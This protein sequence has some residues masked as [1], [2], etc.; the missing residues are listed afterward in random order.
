MVFSRAGSFVQQLLCVLVYFVYGLT[1][2]PIKNGALVL[3]P[4]AEITISGSIGEKCIGLTKAD[5]H[6][7]KRNTICLNNGTFRIL[8]FD[9]LGMCHGDVCHM[10]LSS[11]FTR[12][13]SSHMFFQQRDELFFD[14]HSTE[15]KL[16]NSIQK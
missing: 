15:N 5:G 4:L 7:R 16:L 12:L 11:T 8:P 14:F 13:T 9:G 10:I 6:T 3:V 1:L 2:P